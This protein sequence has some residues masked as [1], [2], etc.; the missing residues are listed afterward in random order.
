[1]NA[2]LSKGKFA[3]LLIL[4]EVFRP[5]ASGRELGFKKAQISVFCENVP[6]IEAYKKVGFREYNT[7]TSASYKAAF[8]CP[9]V[10]NMRMAL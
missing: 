7:V 10:T 6:A 4:P 2:A 3:R 5:C 1:M 9:G 8:N